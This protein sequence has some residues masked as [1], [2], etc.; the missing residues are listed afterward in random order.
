MNSNTNVI[1]L[2]KSN[3]DKID[4]EMLSLNMNPNAIHLLK[5]NQDKIDWEMLSKNPAIFEP[6]IDNRV[7]NELLR[8][9]F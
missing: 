9:R 7:L 2:L 5:S 8:I 3:P 1:R 6:I 4:W